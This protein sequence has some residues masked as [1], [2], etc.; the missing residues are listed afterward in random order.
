MPL[1][2]GRQE[3]SRGGLDVSEERSGRILVL[4]AEG[5]VEVFELRVES[6]RVRGVRT[7]FSTRLF[8]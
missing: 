7:L 4:L 8:T 5:K 6:L 1:T 2:R 3:G